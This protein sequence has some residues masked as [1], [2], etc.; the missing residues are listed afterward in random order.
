LLHDLF[1]LTQLDD[2]PD[3]DA[4]AKF[5][6][7]TRDESE[8]PVAADRQFE[9]IRMRTARARAQLTVR[10]EQIERLNLLD[11]GLQRQGATM[12]VAR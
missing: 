11:D 4:W 3:F 7:D 1:R 6:F 5:Q 10:V 8:E 9:K 12:R 2:A